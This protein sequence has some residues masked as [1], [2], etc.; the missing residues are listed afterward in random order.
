MYIHGMVLSGCIIGISQNDSHS[1]LIINIL[2][3]ST[4]IVSKIRLI[5]NIELHALTVIKQCFRDHLNCLSVIII[6]FTAP[7]CPVKTNKF[8]LNAI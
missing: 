6:M 2:N 7:R 3:D 5:L 8:H 4:G 1:G